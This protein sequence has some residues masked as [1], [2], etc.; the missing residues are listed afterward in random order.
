MVMNIIMLATLLPTYIILFFVLKY[1]GGKTGRFVFGLTLEPEQ[2]KSQEVEEVYRCF[3]RWMWIYFVATVWIPGLAFLSSHVSVQFT[4]WIHWFLLGIFGMAIPYVICNKK[5]CAWKKDEEPETQRLVYTELKTVKTVKLTQFALP[6]LLSVFPPAVLMVL[7]DGKGFNKAFCMAIALFGVCT[8]LFAVLALL[9]D[10]VKVSVIS[11]DSTLNMNYARAKKKIWKDIWV[12]MSWC[13]A[14]LIVLEAFFI[15]FDF[16]PEMAFIIMA[17]SEAVLCL[18]I[19][20][21]NARAMMNLNQAYE[22]RFDIQ[23]SKDSDRYWK[24]GLFYYNSHDPHTVVDKRYGVGTTINM[25]TPV[26]KITMGFTVLCLV[27]IP[28]VCIFMI[29]QEFTPIHLE[30]EN[31]T[32]ICRHMKDEYEI[33]VEDIRMM[34][35]IDR[36]PEGRTKIAGTGMDTLE[37]GRWQNGTYGEFTMFANPENGR[38][39]YIRTED[40]TY[41]IGG[42]DDEE[43]IAIYEKALSDMNR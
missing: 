38:F 43:T 41:F 37:S 15:F 18:M 29:V 2:K 12:S 28:F 21:V 20:W 7:A 16:Y 17:V 1:M 9:L 34:V 11:G 32:V 35:C 23:Y 14:V 36:L 8:A 13:N 30:Y 39:L 24:W 27:W 5:V 42:F 31:K 22:Q 26:G 25:A 40:K 33:P 10:R 4:I 3:H 19:L 6:V